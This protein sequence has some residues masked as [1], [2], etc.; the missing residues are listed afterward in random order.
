MSKKV[1][2]LALNLLNL[3]V[4]ANSPYND[5][6]TQEM[7]RKLYEKELKKQKRYEQN[8]SKQATNKQ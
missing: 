2:P 7:Y 3:Q 5:G 8:R 4:H 1:K 6:W